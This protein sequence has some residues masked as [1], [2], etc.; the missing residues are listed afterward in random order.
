M[1]NIATSLSSI[2]ANGASSA[3]VTRA[4]A[5]VRVA[6][7]MID[8]ATQV[9]VCELC[10]LNTLCVPEGLTRDERT[11]FTA[12][13]AQHRKLE[14]GTALYHA[15]DAFTHLHVVKTGAFKTIVSL[16]DG[17]EQI[18]GFRLP[19]DT[20]GVDAI[21]NNVHASAAI[22]LE[23]SRV[24]AIPFAQ[25]SRMSR[26][27]APVQNYLHRLLAREVVGDQDLMLSLGRMHAEERVAGFLLGLARSH[28]RRGL[29]HSQF[30]LPM[31]REDIGN[32][33]GLTLET[34]SRCLTRLK[35]AGLIRADIRQIQI[36][37]HHG[38]RKVI[39]ARE[40]AH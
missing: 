39:G 25:L 2:G 34:V 4:P 13:V 22:A 27:S 29:S 10:R 9:S 14:I 11:E 7:R 35:K 20:L 36:T 30:T 24:C 23:E 12:L 40:T 18:T 21:G 28:E 8:T 16:D 17:R 6:L 1:L 5:F 3:N 19:G 38:L 15:G 33:L 37:D 31:S 32:Y 26:Q